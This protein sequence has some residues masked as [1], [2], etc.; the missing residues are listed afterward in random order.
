MK[1]LILAPNGG[2]ICCVTHFIGQ[3]CPDCQ[4]FFA[5]PQEALG[6]SAVAEERNRDNEEVEEREAEPNA[7]EEVNPPV[8]PPVEPDATEPPVP[9]ETTEAPAETAVAE[10]TSVSKPAKQP[11]QPKQ[12]K[13]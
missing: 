2:F 6:I 11:K 8:E 1:K 5:N 13:Q 7:G 9:A 10:E 12:P 3:R 4:E